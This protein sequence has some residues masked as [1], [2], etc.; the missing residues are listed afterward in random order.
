MFKVPAK[1]H[2]L[3][4]RYQKIYLNMKYIK[5]SLIFIFL[6]CLHV[7]LVLVF[8]L[9]FYTIYFLNLILVAYLVSLHYS[10]YSRIILFLHVA[11]VLLITKSDAY[12]EI[13][14]E[15]SLLFDKFYVFPY[16]DGG[17]IY[18]L[19]IIHILVF[20]NL[21]RFESIWD[22]IDKKLSRN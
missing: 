22:I 12:D 14:F 18:A 20:I 3:L 13:L 10:S 2:H 5:Q 17:I 4:L 9:H 1:V 15:F 6:L 11:I 16:I 8:T 21:K 7:E 19:S